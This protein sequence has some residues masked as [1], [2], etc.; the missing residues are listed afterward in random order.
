MDFSADTNVQMMN[1]KN[2]ISMTEPSSTNNQDLLDLL[3]LGGGDVIPTT[4]AISPAPLGILN[5]NDLTGLNVNNSPAPMQILGGLGSMGNELSINNTVTLGDIT[6]TNQP[7]NMVLNLAN[8]F[9]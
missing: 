9:F 6:N 5:G 8:I 3:G 4:T 1:N 7:T 2:T